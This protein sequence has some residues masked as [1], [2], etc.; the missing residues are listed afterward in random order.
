[1]SVN[2]PVPFK[3]Q[4]DS[5]A[6][7]TRNDCGPASIAMVLNHLG[8]KASTDAVFAKTGAGLGLITVAQLQ[9]AITAYGL[10]SEFLTNCT[11]EKLKELLEQGI[12]PIALV[13]YGSLKSTQDKEFKGGHFFTV[14]GYRDDGYFVNDP[15]FKEQYR[16]DGDHHNYTK[17]EFEKSWSD[18]HLDGNPDNCLLI[19]YPNQISIALSPIPGTREYDERKAIE[20]LYRGLATLKKEDGTALGGNLEGLSNMLV[21][22]A[23][24]SFIMTKINEHKPQIDPVNTPTLVTLDKEVLNVVIPT[25]APTEQAK[26]NAFVKLVSS[27]GALFGI[28]ST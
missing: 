7:A 10:R 23:Y 4:W 2:L 12:A 25:D 6:E 13:H 20:T 1:M 3:S 8:I 9:K 18:C 27:L 19:I 14:V 26:Q 15:N 17:E 28:K 22:D 21:L 24:P 11:P 16:S 5:D